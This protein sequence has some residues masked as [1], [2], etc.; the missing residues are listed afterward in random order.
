M[1]AHAQDYAFIWTNG[2]FRGSPKPPSGLR[3]PYS[4]RQ[5]SLRAILIP[6]YYGKPVGFH[7][8][9]GRVSVDFT[10][11]ASIVP[12]MRYC[13]GTWC[14]AGHTEHCLPGT[15]THLKKNYPDLWSP[16]PP[17]GQINVLESS[18]SRGPI[19]CLLVRLNSGQK[20]QADK[21]TCICQNI[22][23]A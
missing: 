21:D 16:A 20:A 22:L 10:P 7:Q 4:S 12:R 13:S 14:V 5:D 19:T 23:G 2:K 15:L 9:Q 6:V 11:E 8:S 3:I 18:S 1:R 17:W